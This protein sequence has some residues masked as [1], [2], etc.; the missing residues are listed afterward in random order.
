M[1]IGLLGLGAALGFETAPIDGRTAAGVF[2]PW[3]S[4]GHVVDAA[5][6]AG[7]VAAA[8][9]VPFI[10]VIHAPKGD[11]SARLLDAGA[12]FILDPG[13]ARACGA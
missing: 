8:G 5:S 4:A 11:A 3:W 1:L 10:V 12:L 2:P 7:P 13:L 9:A 6:R